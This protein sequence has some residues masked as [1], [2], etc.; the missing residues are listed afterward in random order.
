MI[1]DSAAGWSLHQQ[2]AADTVPLGDLPLARILI[3]QDAHYPWLIL[4][5]RR[6][7]ATEIIDLAEDDQAQLTR[8]IAA[9]SHALRHVTH[10]AKLNVAALGNAVSQ[11]HVHIIARRTDDAAW[12]RPVWGVVPPAPYEP[13]KLD[14]LM[15]AI[16]HRLWPNQPCSPGC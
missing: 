3:M 10:C 8:E 7:G 11:L 12:P 1:P 2:L 13:A 16:R 4:V 5:P 9:A 15:V 6:P 14:A